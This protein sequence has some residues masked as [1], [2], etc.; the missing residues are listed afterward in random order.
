MRLDKYLSDMKCGT[1]SQLKKDI[2]NGLVTVDGIIIRQSDYQV[3]ETKNAVCYRGEPCVYEKYI[4]YML[5]KPSGVVSATED[6]REKTVLSLLPENIR[7]GLFPVG[8]L[9]KDTEGLLLLTDDGG[10]SHEL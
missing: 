6:K 2:K 7:K 5:N 3:D 8:R 9:D 10:L 1:R 4:Y